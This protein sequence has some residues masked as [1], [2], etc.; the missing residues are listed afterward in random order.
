MF[1]VAGAETVLG[2]SPVA[3]VVYLDENTKSPR[4]VLRLR[5][6]LPNMSIAVKPLGYGAKIVSSP[7]MQRNGDNCDALCEKLGV[8]K[9]CMTAKTAAGHA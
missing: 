9:P 8:E 4:H 3:I 7:T 1:A 2:D 5:P 6:C